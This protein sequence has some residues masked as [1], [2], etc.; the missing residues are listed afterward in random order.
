MGIGSKAD[1]A[2]VVVSVPTLKNQKTMSNYEQWSRCRLKK[3][4]TFHTTVKCFFWPAISSPAEL[5]VCFRTAVA[6]LL[7]DWFLPCVKVTPTTVSF[8]FALSIRT[9]LKSFQQS[10]LKP[11]VLSGRLFTQCHLMRDL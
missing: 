6:G 4:H 5:V 11:V 2:M 7:V 10:H 9:G 3:S 1:V 8:S